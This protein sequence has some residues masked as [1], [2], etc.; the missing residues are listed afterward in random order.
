MIV[1]LQNPFAEAVSSCTLLIGYYHGLLLRDINADLLID[2]M[3]STKLLTADE[4]S[5]ISSGCSIYQRNWLLLEHVRHKDEGFLSEFCKLLIQMKLPE[6]GSQLNVGIVTTHS[7]QE[8]LLHLLQS[9]LTAAGKGLFVYVTVRLCMNL[10]V[11][12]HH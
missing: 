11:Y 1:S 6:I 5:L 7:W 12:I 3:C 2:K 9:P 8:A 10:L 4:K